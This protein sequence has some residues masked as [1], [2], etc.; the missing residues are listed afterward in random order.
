M[1]RQAPPPINTAF[2]DGQLAPFHRLPAGDLRAA[3][4]GDHPTDR[5]ALAGALTEYLTRLGAPKASL[6]AAARLVHPQ[7]RVVVAGQQAGL[8]GGPAY[9]PYKAAN[10]IL[11]ARELDSEERPV[12]PVFWI[13]TQDHDAAEVSDTYLLDLDDTL[14]RLTLPLPSGRP[15]GRLKLEAE[16]VTRTLTALR[17][18]HGPQEWKDLVL[19]E[20]EAAAGGARTYADWFARLTMNLFAAHGLVALDPLDPGI[21]ALFREPLL[22]EIEDPMAGPLAIEEAAHGLESLGYQPQLRRPSGATNL[23]LEGPDGQRRLLRFDGRHFHAETSYTAAQLQRIV[24]LEP[25][26]LT[27][28]AGLR[29]VMADAILPTAVSILGPSE[30]SYQLELLGVYQRHNIP[31]PLL[32]QRMSVTW[33]ETPVR[34]ALERYGLTAQE[35]MRAPEASIAEVRL[36][37]TG[38]ADA[39]RAGLVD[40]ELAFERLAHRLDPLDPTL[41]G[42][43]TRS[44]SRVIGH[45][46]RLERK[47]GSALVRSEG[48]AERSL[49]RLRRN[50][51]P[52]GTPQERKLN[53]F[54]YRLKYGPEPLE[55]LLTLEPSG[56]HFLDI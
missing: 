52:G 56:A 24:A 17:A 7:S 45:V 13:A 47:V 14:H 8:L 38:A 15:V 42:A 18:F 25:G 4:S 48:L 28:A 54:T 19:G 34:R 9:S 3:I 11:L 12:V 51:L 41:E 2:R 26:R 10:A 53:F 50:L 39:F 16:W 31:Q 32:W 27:P 29:P 43:L 20:V 44:R 22:R 30:L 40:L 36:R 5:Q 1:T 33:L 55:R 49:D 6:E 35:F 37:Q 46:S 23:F 21:A